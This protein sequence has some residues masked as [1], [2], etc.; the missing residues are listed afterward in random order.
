MTVSELAR[1]AG[2]TANTVSHYILS[3]LL[4]PIRDELFWIVVIKAV[5]SLLTP[6][7]AQDTVNE[8]VGT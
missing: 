3:G 2:V 5:F 4:V 1:R 6:V 7:A 8:V